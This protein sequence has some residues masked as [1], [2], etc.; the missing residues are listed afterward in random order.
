VLATADSNYGNYKIVE[1][2]VAK[3]KDNLAGLTPQKLSQAVYDA[4]PDSAYARGAGGDLRDLARTGTVVFQNVSPP[5]GARL[6]TLGAAGLGAL[7][8]AIGIPAATAA[9]GLTG[10]ETGRRLAAGMTAPQ[11]AVQK[12]GS[13][14]NSAV[15][16]LGPQA[17]ARLSVGAGIPVTQQALPAALAAALLYSQPKPNGN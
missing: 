9:L 13:A 10:T 8:P 2:A 16:T 7:H 12:L 3:A 17:A 11:R 6:A 4:V 5:T 15:P 14:L 1:N